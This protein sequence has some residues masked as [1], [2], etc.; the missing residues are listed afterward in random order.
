MGI[1]LRTDADWPQI[2][3]RTQ[4]QTNILTDLP[5]KGGAVPEVTYSPMKQKFLIQ[6]MDGFLQSARVIMTLERRWILELPM[7]EPTSLS[8]MLTDEV[9]LFPGDRY[10]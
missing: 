2:I 8:G 6:M 1:A 7:Q 4:N 5:G 3:P 9:D 10:G